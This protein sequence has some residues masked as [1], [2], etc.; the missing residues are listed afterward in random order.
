LLVVFICAT[1]ALPLEAARFAVTSVYDKSMTTPMV[2]FEGRQATSIDLQNIVDIGADSAGNLYVLAGVPRFV[3]KIP[4]D[5]ILQVI[6]GGGNAAPGGGL[7]ARQANFGAVTRLAVAPDGAVYI[8]ETNQGCVYRFGADGIL[9]LIAGTGESGFGGDGGPATAAMLRFP[10]SMALDAQGN[11]Y[12]ADN[13][14]S[15]IRKV[16][17]NTGIITTIAGTGTATSSGD[18]GPATQ[19]GVIPDFI[20]VDAAGNIYFTESPNIIRK[21]DSSGVITKLGGSGNS[22]AENIPA[23]Q[24]NFYVIF[25]MAVASDGR[26]YVSVMP[27]LTSSAVVRGIAIRTV[28][29]AGMVTTFAGGVGR[30]IS[31]DG[32]AAGDARVSYP[33]KIA[34]SGN[35]LWFVDYRTVRLVSDGIIRTVAGNHSP[36][37]SGEGGPLVESKLF[38]MSAMTSDQAGNF[39]FADVYSHSV[40]RADPDLGGLRRIAGTGYPGYTGENGP[41][42]QMAFNHPL[43]VEVDESGNLYVADYNNSRICRIAPSGEVTTVAGATGN[44]GE[45]SFSEGMNALRFY[46]DPVGLRWRAGFLYFTDPYGTIYKLSQSGT[47]SRF[48]QNDTSFARTRGM[49]FDS[50]GNVYVADNGGH[51]V[52]KITSGGT[53]SVIAGTG[54]VGFSGDGGPAAAARLNQPSDVKVDTAG[55]VYVMDSMNNRL[56]RVSPQG[57]IETVAGGGSGFRNQAEATSIALWGLSEYFASLHLEPDGR[58]WLN[59]NFRLTRLETARLFTNWVY[60]CA[61]FVSGGVA[62]GECVAFYGEDIGPDSLVQAAYD[63]NGNLAR[64]AAGTEVLVNGVPAPMIFTS[65]DFNAFLMP[66]GILGAVTL[67]VRRPGGTTNSITLNVVP[68]MPGLFTYAGG[69]G[70]I[71]AVNAE[72]LTFNG[73]SQPATRGQWMTIF[74]TGQGQVT[75]QVGDGVAI[76]NLGPYPAP[77]APVS[78][79]V[80]GVAVPSGDIWTGLTFQGVLQINFKVPEAAP[81]GDQ[82]VVVTIGSASSQKSATVNLK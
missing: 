69:T 59:D 49:D 26:L 47:L 74:A 56:R 82:P 46:F 45:T 62:P 55:N 57:T 5:G 39:Y 81:A 8:N 42:R 13:R 18:G 48:Y 12:I 19:A 29:P 9:R 25:G 53:A 40:Y 32:G 36:E 52:L 61:S 77:V 7:N 38:S 35:K 37:V 4:P 16:D 30:Q 44:D 21:I 51:R 23:S 68:T 71:V 22:R 54:Q 64:S 10:R 73:P 70:Q 27:D 78:I 60:N 20:G 50:Q 17:R 67:E 80:G 15:R 79:T 72:N 65:K 2:Y 58:L 11:L 14:N 31:G 63:N 41:G 34:V 75:P 3:G 76:P 33:S 66:Y 1:Y 6:G 28:S 43:D 24:A